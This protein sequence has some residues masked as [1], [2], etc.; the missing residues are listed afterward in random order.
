[1][2]GHNNRQ[3]HFSVF[4]VHGGLN[5][6][7]VPNPSVSQILRNLFGGPS[8]TANT[9]AHTGAN[10]V[11]HD[12]QGSLQPAQEPARS[13]SDEDTPLPL[14]PA[15]HGARHDTDNDSMPSLQSI[16]ESSDDDDGNHSDI[17]MEEM[18]QPAADDDDGSMP[19][20]EPIDNLN[21]DRTAPAAESIPRRAGSRRPRSEVDDDQTGSPRPSRRPRV[22]VED[23][24]DEDSRVHPTPNSQ[25]QPQPASPPTAGEPHSRMQPPHAGIAITID[26]VRGVRVIPLGG[27]LGGTG[28]RLGAGGA[29]EPFGGPRFFQRFD[30][31]APNADAPAGGPPPG[32]LPGGFNLVDFFT[33]ID[34]DP[35]MLFRAFED[36]NREDPERAQKLVDGLEVVPVGLV[37]RMEKVG[38]AGEQGGSSSDSDAP[39]CAVCWD[40]LLEP[41]GEGF[42]VPAQNG[43]DGS[44]TPEEASSSGQQKE[45]PKIV[46][47][48]C[49]HVFHASCLIPWFSRPRQTTCPTCRFNIDPE[50]LTYRPP[51]PQS[52]PTQVRAQASSSVDAQPRAASASATVPEAQV[53]LP[54]SPQR[55]PADIP[56]PDS[57]PSSP[58]FQPWTRIPSPPRSQ[59]DRQPPR[60]PIPLLH[61]P[62]MPPPPAPASNMPADNVP[63]DGPGAGPGAG[64]SINIDFV[65]ELPEAMGPDGAPPPDLLGGAAAQATIR[66][67]RELLSRVGQPTPG[68]ALPTEGDAGARRGRGFPFVFGPFPREGQPQAPRR[69]PKEWTLP[70]APG[71]TVR[72]RVEKRERELGLRCAD[73]S[74]GV[75]PSD[76]DPS[77][78]MSAELLKEIIVRAAEG[79]EGQGCGHTFHPAC[80]VS[81]E[82]V[83]GW[84][85]E[86]KS[87]GDVDVSCPACRTVGVVS[88][89][90]WDEGVKTLA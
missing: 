26:P 8:R 73:P 76:D 67:M 87:E 39:G 41:E 5:R 89:A 82:R 2:D 25:P 64:P 33:G 53:P 74:C 51:Q 83:A 85:G 4:N 31:S 57:R 80:L 54:P 42:G 84:D 12:T 90:D 49:A 52:P 7:R 48:P 55:L 62:H 40:R 61:F 16:S 3:H 60:Q 29:P 66:I 14:A 9:D 59:T 63:R 15:R 44:S 43:E 22:E 68:S 17:E 77:P 70:P 10:N 30:P 21:L 38:S 1:M 88:R 56:L 37:K 34:V 86:E 18:L 36:H 79:V 50:N 47:L 81:A 46:S 65:F 75:G 58:P 32:G 23:I 24:Q 72:Q 20:L 19:A 69:E 27:P 35:T 6:N 11:R 45:N 28:D 71:L 13:S 78:A